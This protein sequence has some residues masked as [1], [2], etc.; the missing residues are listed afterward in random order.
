MVE[1]LLA[2]LPGG[3]LNGTDLYL[4]TTYNYYI[5]TS[6]SMFTHC[7]WDQHFLAKCELLLLWKR[8]DPHRDSSEPGG[9]NLCA[10]V[11]ANN[12]HLIRDHMLWCVYDDYTR[13]PQCAANYFVRQH[14]VMRQAAL[15]LVKNKI[16]LLSTDYATKMR[17]TRN[18]LRYESCNA[19]G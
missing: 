8:R 11:T 7:V 1:W 16:W 19:K 5:I 3:T 13:I 4:Y 10:A 12:P 15:V 17:L 6:M 9:Q 18:K 14:R 2:M